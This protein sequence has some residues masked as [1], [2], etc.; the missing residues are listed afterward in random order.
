MHLLLWWRLVNSV[1]IMF[2]SFSSFLSTVSSPAPGIQKTFS[3]CSLNCHV[4]KSKAMW[5]KEAKAKDLGWEL[6]E[7]YLTLASSLSRRMFRH[8]LNV[9]CCGC[10]W[11]QLAALRPIFFLFC[12]QDVQGQT[13]RPCWCRVG[14]TPMGLSLCCTLGSPSKLV[15]KCHLSREGP[16]YQYSEQRPL[17]FWYAARIQTHRA[18]Q[19]GHASAHGAPPTFM[20]ITWKPGNESLRN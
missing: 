4:A 8:S 14:A 17:W 11:P 18:R 16:R 5:Q 20:G 13:I 9:C 3:K 6:P 1:R 2:I 12:I 7:Y 19:E 10:C 15:E